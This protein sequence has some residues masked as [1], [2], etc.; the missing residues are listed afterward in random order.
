M[1]ILEARGLEIQYPEIE[2][3]SKSDIQE[4]RWRAVDRSAKTTAQIKL[5]KWWGKPKLLVWLPKNPE[6]GMASIDSYVTVSEN[7]THI[8]HFGG[9]ISLGKISPDIFMSLQEMREYLGYY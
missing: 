1:T 6:D 9:Q 2:G 4:I 7:R 5:T 8:N 3:S